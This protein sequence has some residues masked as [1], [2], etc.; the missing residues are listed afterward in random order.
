MGSE[1]SRFLLHLHH[2]PE[3]PVALWVQQ[4][5]AEGRTTPLTDFHDLFAADPDLFAPIH[6]WIR[7]PL[8]HLVRREQGTVRSHAIRGAQVATLADAFRNR[9]RDLGKRSHTREIHSEENLD[10]MLDELAATGTRLALAPR[11][12]ASPSLLTFLHLDALARRIVSTRRVVP[13]LTSTQFGALAIWRPAPGTIAADGI[14]IPTAHQP[15]ALC[16]TLIDAHARR[17]FG[18]ARH[19]RAHEGA[20]VRAE[21]LEALDPRGAQLLDALGPEDAGLTLSP[22]EQRRLAATLTRYV[23]SGLTGALL[24]DREPHLVVRVREGG[25]MPDGSDWMIEVCLRESGGAVHPLDD[26]VAVGDLAPSAALSHMVRV[27]THA[28]TLSSLE[29]SGQAWRVSTGQASAFLG[30]DAFELEQAGIAVLMPREWAKKPVSLRAQVRV[31]EEPHA[32]GEGERASGSGVGRAI[33][34]FEFRLAIGEVEL[35]EEE[36]QKLIEEQSELV[37]LRGQWVRVDASTLRAAENFLAAFAKA[38]RAS[39]DPA[40]RALIQKRLLTGRRASAEEFR[41]L[42]REAHSAMGVVEITASGD[43]AGA[44]SGREFLFGA[45]TPLPRLPHPQTL[46]AHLRPYQQRGLDWLTFLDTHALG[47]ILAD[48]MGLGKTMQV[49][50]LLLREREDPQG[51]GWGQGFGGPTLLVCPMSVLGSWQREAAKFA[52]GLRV[53]VHHGPD[54]AHFAHLKDAVGSADL[55]ITTYALVVRDHEELCEIPF[56]RVIFDEAQH[57]KNADTHVSQAARTLAPGRRLALTGTPVEN[58]LTDLHSIMQVT[59]PGL[60]PRS[61]K[62]FREKFATPIADGDEHTAAQLSALIRP[63]VLR[64]VKTDR[65][66]ITDLPDKR[67]E[68]TFVNITPEQAALYQALV[69]QMNEELANE[70]EKSGTAAQ[71]GTAA[72]PGFKKRAI[73]AATLMR[74]KQVLG[75]PAHY[76]ADGSGILDDNGEHRSGKLERV[77]DLLS[78]I[79]TS[80]EKALIFTQFT[81]FAPTMIA[82]WE[83]QFGITVPFLHGGIHKAHRDAMVHE[84]QHSP[85]SPGAMLLSLRA[86]GTGITLTAAN[87]VIH[88]DRWWNPAVENQ[89]T[90]RAFRIGQKRNVQVHKLISIGTI[91]EQIDRVL[92]DKDM[93]ARTTIRQGE[94]WLAEL[95]PEQLRDMFTLRT[96][97]TE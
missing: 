20:L 84:F 18:R 33:G 91:E 75:H 67:E 74:M 47:G 80:G 39:T 85:H 46:K 37:K 52:P 41:S 44:G 61:E 82:H 95:S 21:E 16:L 40:S 50:A 25:L 81:N 11:I 2:A 68:R 1:I 93:V 55:V 3:E 58:D 73:I 72:P 9:I 94:A 64:R 31:E 45:H 22:H 97:E 90:D 10:A 35:S 32:P 5:D 87:H 60:L 14:R 62:E 24:K 13:T 92:T 57:V 53:Y 89:A 51:L 8:R 30:A 66:I 76:L 42:L 12:F 48:D 7:S 43:G 29:P 86:G 83:Q 88:L 38:E 56:H 26:L 96:G 4:V 59:N 19:R 71:P 69:E 77:D 23:D 28:P 27:R 63:Y 54:R 6:T 17:E 49:L 70:G 34:S 65:S 15:R 36:A 78:A 79:I